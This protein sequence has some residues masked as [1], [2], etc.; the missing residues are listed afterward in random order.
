M[1]AS[2]FTRHALEHP[3]TRMINFNGTVYFNGTVHTSACMLASMLV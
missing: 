3:Q 2:F 1:L